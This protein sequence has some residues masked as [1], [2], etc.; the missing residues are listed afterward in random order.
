MFPDRRRLNIQRIVAKNRRLDKHTD[1]VVDAGKRESF[2]GPSLTAVRFRT[3]PM[4]LGIR[5]ALTVYV[6]C[7]VVL[8]FITATTTGTST[9][10]TTAT[11]TTSTT[12]ITN[13]VM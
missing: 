5:S 6:Y 11:T 2:P 12:T 4:L 3:Y 8:L 13:W 10:P 7:F 1:R 9:T